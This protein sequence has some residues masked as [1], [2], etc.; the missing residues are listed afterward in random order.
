MNVL[1]VDLGGQS[2]RAIV[3]D[4]AG[5]PIADATAPTGRGS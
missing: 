4:D 3:F 5:V 1:A 2:A